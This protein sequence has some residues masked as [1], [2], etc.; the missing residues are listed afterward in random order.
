MEVAQLA[1]D[2]ARELAVNEDLA[3][4]I[5]LAHDIGHSP[6]GHAGEAALDAM[7]KDHGGFDHNAQ[8]IRFIT[9]LERRYL[10][11]DGLNMTWETLEGIAKHNGPVTSPSWAMLEYNNQHDLALDSYASL[12]AQIAALCDDIAYNNHDIEDGLRANL[13][14]VRAIKELPVFGEKYV[15][16]EREHV[17]ADLHRLIYEAKRFSIYSMMRDLITETKQAI[18]GRA[19]KHVDEVRGAGEMLAT[20]SESMQAH[21]ATIKSFLFEHMYTHYRVNRMTNKAQQIIE[22]LYTYFWEQ[23]ESMPTLWKQTADL[24]KSDTARAR[25]DQ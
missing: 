5:A 13:F 11:F 24:A 3:E 19:P 25:V 10:A 7:M 12:E 17:G 16:L 18:S 6:F 23:P 1:R 9:H 2:A 15:E 4:T 14:P 20:L 8:T 21:A 22:E